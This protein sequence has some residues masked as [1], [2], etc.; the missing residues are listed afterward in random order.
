MREMTRLVC[1][2]HSTIDTIY[3]V[4]AI[5]STPMKVLA[6]AYAEAGGGMAANASVAAARLGGIVHYWG[7]VGDDAPGE[8][9]VALLEAEGVQTAAVRRIAGARS[10]CT[11]VL[12]DDRGERLICT[13]ND[14]ALDA[15]ATWLPTASLIDVDVVLA[16]VR[17]PAGAARALAAARAAGVPAVL[18]GD[19]APVATL[20]E[21]C[22]CCDY[23]IFSQ[24]GLSL[25]SGAA[26]IGEGLRRM[27]EIAGGMVGVTLG[28]D[29]FLWLDAGHERRAPPPRV[30][31]VDT[32]AAGDVFHAA[33]ALAIGERRA[34]ADAAAFANA[35][36]A[37][38]CTRFG[39]RLGAPVRAEVEALLRSS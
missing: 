12:V 21:L 5:P 36:A 15:D 32:L 38:K 37:L 26:A 30:V 3:Q 29:G 34:V 17:W 16:D 31:A 28:A 19:V 22:R 33:F 25:A 10:P 39:G 13:Y 27:Q 14:P 1:V 11:A 24:P 6:N 8:R 18:D 35:A 9:I 20:R 7:R 23:A 2:G 4:A